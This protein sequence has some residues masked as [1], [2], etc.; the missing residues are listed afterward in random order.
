MKKFSQEATHPARA[1]QAWQILI[2]AAMNRQ[3]H[4][5]KS[6]S[7]LMYGNPAQGV[8]ARVLG[9]IALYCHQNDLPLLTVLVVNE[10]TGLP[11]EG[12]PTSGDLHSLRELVFRTD[13][14]SIYPPTEQE[15]EEAYKS[16]SRTEEGQ[17]D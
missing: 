2:A 14:Y 16:N 12:I 8:I 5:Y 4:T 6:L 13:W 10:K 3:T 1:L 9:H 11:G 7:T 15:L 17:V